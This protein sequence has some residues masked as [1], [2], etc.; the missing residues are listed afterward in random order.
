MLVQ[1]F[2]PDDRNYRQDVWVGARMS[3]GAVTKTGAAAMQERE[4]LGCL[5]GS[6]F[7]L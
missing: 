5:S 4:T 6:A 2:F 3:D 1:F 7:A